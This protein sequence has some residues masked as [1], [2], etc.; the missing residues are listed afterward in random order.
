MDTTLF[1]LLIPQDTTGNDVVESTL[2]PPVIP[3]HTTEN[4]VVSTVEVTSFP[5]LK[6]RHHNYHK[7]PQLR[8]NK[9]PQDT[10]NRK[11]Q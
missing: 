2:F 9:I 3:Q 10:T 7:I 8:N 1:R 5:L 4:N 11:Q 6:T